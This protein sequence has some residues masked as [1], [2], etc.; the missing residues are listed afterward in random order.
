MEEAEGRGFAVAAGKRFWEKGFAVA[1][2]KR[3]WEK[4]FAVAAEISSS[5]FP[6]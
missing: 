5:S 4:G 3:S 2:E 1:V 6:S